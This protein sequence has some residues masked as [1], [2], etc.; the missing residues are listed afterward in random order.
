MRG[1]SSIVWQLFH[2][3]GSW[4]LVGCTDIADSSWDRD[5]HTP[6]IQSERH[7]AHVAPAAVADAGEDAAQRPSDAS[8]VAAREPGNS[9]PD[10][11]DAGTAAGRGSV[12]LV[13]HELWTMLGPAEDPFDDRPLLVECT[14]AAVIAETLADEPA[15]GVDTGLCNYLTVS[16]PTLEDV[17]VGQTLKVRLWHFALTAPEPAEAHAALL[18]DGMEVM[19]E[20]LP[21]PA[22]GGLIVKEVRAARAIPAGSPVFFHLHNHGMNSWALVELSRSGG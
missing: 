9:D 5:D 6:E 21:I 20:K 3:A 18:V 14:R 10:V 22:P 7:D 19:D 11:L 17:A 2:L 8:T 4:A 16:Q 15:L 12:S 13:A 1:F